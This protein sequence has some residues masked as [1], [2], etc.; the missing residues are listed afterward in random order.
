MVSLKYP[1]V[2]IGP[3]QKGHSKATKRGIGGKCSERPWCISLGDIWFFCGKKE[4]YFVTLLNM[5]AKFFLVA[6]CHF[7]RDA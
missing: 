3:W 2:L 5:A 4:G 1:S 6:I 7:C